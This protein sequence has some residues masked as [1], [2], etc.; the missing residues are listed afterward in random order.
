[1]KTMRTSSANVVTK[2]GGWSQ[3]SLFNSEQL[4]PYKKNRWRYIQAR[5]AR[6]RQER[7]REPRATTE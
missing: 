4:R 1:M 2:V 3:R 6:E 7:E 5:L